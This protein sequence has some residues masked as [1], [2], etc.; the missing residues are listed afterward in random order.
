MYF[1][2]KK[3]TK[4]Q[5]IILSQPDFVAK[6]E[7]KVQAPKNN[8]RGLR[9][10]PDCSKTI[11]LDQEMDFKK[12]P[13]EKY[14]FI[15]EKNNFEKKS[16]E[17]NLK[18]SKISIEKS[19]F[20]SKNFTW[21]NRFSRQNFSDFEIFSKS[22]FSKSFFSMM[23]K[24]FLIRIFLKHISDVRRIDCAQKIQ[25]IRGLNQYIPTK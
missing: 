9:N 8:D 11:V 25:Y 24:Y 13:V 21:E 23:K 22:I 12:N 14:F 15:F 4:Y 5:K 20:P 16:R 2:F 1:L 18:K 6:L 19:I 17:K 7:K 10:H 3:K